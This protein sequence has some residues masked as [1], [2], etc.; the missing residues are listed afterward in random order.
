MSKLTLPLLALLLAAVLPLRAAAADPAPAPRPVRA[1]IVTGVDW[2]GHLWK[3]T[4]VAVQ[5]ILQADARCEAE[6]VSDPGFLADPR[7]DDFDVVVLMFKNYAPLAKE[8][9]ALQHL[10]RFVHNGKGLSV[11]HF[12]SGAFPV[13]ASENKTLPIRPEFRD[14]IGRSQFKRHDKRGPFLVKIARTDGPITLGMSDFETDD[15]LFIDLVGDRPI[16]VLATAH[17]KITNQDHP[18]AFVFTNEKGRVFQTTLGHDTKALEVPGT[19]ELIRRGT[20][21]AAGRP[22]LESSGP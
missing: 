21:W 5:G 9:E 18:M 7:L 3:R 8:D 4:S 1:V 13:E 20:M 14:L 19:R 12:A 11:I 6:I 2:P 10:I 16:E 17:S 22:P 15:E